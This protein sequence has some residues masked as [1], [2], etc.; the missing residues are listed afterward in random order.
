MVDRIARGRVWTAKQAHDLG[1]VDQM[2]GLQDAIADAVNRAGLTDNH[3]VV[4]VEERLSLTEQL[5]VDF[6]A[7]AAG[8]IDFQPNPG[9]A[10]VKQLLQPYEAEISLL[11][12]QQPGQVLNMAHCFCYQPQL[13]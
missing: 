10:R 11:L 4:Y 8:Y 3:A 9:L 12:S 6:M 1:L 5:L 2:G 7:K 13:P